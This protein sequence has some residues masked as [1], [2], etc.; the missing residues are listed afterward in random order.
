MVEEAA[1]PY[2]QLIRLPLTDLI[3]GLRGRTGHAVLRATARGSFQKGSL[4]DTNQWPA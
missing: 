4:V 3:K 1:A 2:C